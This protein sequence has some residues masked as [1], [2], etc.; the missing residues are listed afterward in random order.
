MAQPWL[1][2]PSGH[3]VRKAR[4]QHLQAESTN[5]KGG[6]NPEQPPKGGRASVNAGLEH[7]LQSLLLGWRDLRYALLG[8]GRDGPQG[9]AGFFQALPQLGAQYRAPSTGGGKQQGAG[10]RTGRD[11]PALT[12]HSR[13]PGPVASS[14]WEGK[15]GGAGK[16]WEG[17]SL[18]PPYRGKHLTTGL[19]GPRHTNH[20]GQGHP[21]PGPAAIYRPQWVACSQC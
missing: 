18:M 14:L 8:V 6:R 10:G 12:E 7:H 19:L 5:V 3:P 1:P 9:Q 17:G 16:H 20:G 15:V 11:T 2:G 4:A 13:L 21:L